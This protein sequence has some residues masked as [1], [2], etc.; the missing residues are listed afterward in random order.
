ML[1]VSVA[2]ADAAGIVHVIELSVPDGSTLEDVIRASGIL[3]RCPDVDPSRA[4][5]GVFNR[6]RAPGDHVKD[7]DRVEIY[8]P[9]LADPKDSRRRRAR[10]ARKEG[11]Q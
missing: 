7:G 4:D 6:L 11:K 1:N 5:V 10:S 9:L 2:C 3:Q 8:R